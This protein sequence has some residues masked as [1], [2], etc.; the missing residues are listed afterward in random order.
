MNPIKEQFNR[1][2][3]NGYIEVD[4]IWK[5]CRDYKVSHGYVIICVEEGEEWN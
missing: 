4:A 1:L 5:I 2:I 3:E